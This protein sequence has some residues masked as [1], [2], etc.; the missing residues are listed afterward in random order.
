MCLTRGF[1]SRWLSAFSSVFHSP[2]DFS[3]TLRLTE[4][5]DELT[6]RQA[7]VLCP[8]DPR[9]SVANSSP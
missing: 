4:Q 7:K 1:V 3:R 6:R 9:V 8:V 2:A 5:H